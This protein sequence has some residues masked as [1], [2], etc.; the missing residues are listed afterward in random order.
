[1]TAGTRIVAVA[2]A[3]VDGGFAD[4]LHDELVVRLDTGFVLRRAKI[5]SPTGETDWALET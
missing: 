2:G 5:K 3:D 1:V 4:K